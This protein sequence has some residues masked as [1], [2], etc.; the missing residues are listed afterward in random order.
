MTLGTMPG[1]NRKRI[2]AI[3]TRTHTGCTTTLPLTP[4][5]PAPMPRPPQQFLHPNAEQ[6]LVTKDR[7]P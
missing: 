2:T 6:V 4:L 1:A 7:E 3:G 5:S